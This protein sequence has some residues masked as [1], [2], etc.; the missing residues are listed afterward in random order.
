MFYSGIQEGP[1][2]NFLRNTGKPEG[3][4]WVWSVI[5]LLVLPCPALPSYRKSCL[6][7]RMFYIVL[8]LV[9]VAS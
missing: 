3:H 9:V 2:V 1:D 4:A 7:G 6:H 5:M 8:V